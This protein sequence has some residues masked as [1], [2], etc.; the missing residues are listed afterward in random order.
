MPPV[1]EGYYGQDRGVMRLG[2]KGA[3]VHIHHLAQISGAVGLL[4]RP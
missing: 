3:A 4:P 2:F 1:G